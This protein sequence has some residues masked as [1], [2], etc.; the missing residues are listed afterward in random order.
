MKIFNKQNIN[1]LYWILNKPF[2]IIAIRS[3]T[4]QKWNKIKNFNLGD[5]LNFYMLRKLTGK[6][7]INYNDMRKPRFNI[8]HYTCIGSVFEYNVDSSSIVWGTGSMYGGLK[9]FIK[10][11]KI[12]AV[13]GPLTRKALINQGIPCPEVYGDPALLLP[14]VYQPET[15]KKYKLGIIPHYVDYNLENVKTF[16]TNHKDTICLIQMQN[17]KDW[18]D[19]IDDICSCECIASSSLHGMI[20]SDAYNI[21]NVWIRLSDNISG[22][23]FKYHDYFESVG[24]FEKE[25]LDFRDILIDYEQIMT[26]SLQYKS[27]QIDI[28]KLI[29][30]CPFL[31]EKKKKCIVKSG[32]VNRQCEVNT[33]LHG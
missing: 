29:E 30:A 3:Y 4:F 33:K 19:V 24:R 22:G 5:D 17:Y 20:I 25:P 1:L 12:C 10:P 16:V 2:G 6:R 32:K 31:P 7:I 27:I 28:S 26:C 11:Q 18:R 14:L 23:N 21:P 15:K 13:R 9:Q 8:T